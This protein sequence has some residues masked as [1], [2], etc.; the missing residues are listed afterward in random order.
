MAHVY[1]PNWRIMV[2]GLPKQK[3]NETPISIDNPVV[4]VHICDSNYVGGSLYEASSGQKVRPYLEN[5]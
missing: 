1:N 4:V 5:K 3:S 2:W